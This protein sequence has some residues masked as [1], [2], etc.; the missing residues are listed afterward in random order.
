MSYL[1]DQNN[2]LSML[3]IIDW[4]IL[5]L[6]LMLTLV[7]P[8]FKLKQFN[9]RH[10][11]K[12][13]EDVLAGRQ[14]TMVPFVATLF[15]TWYGG[16]FG[17]SEIAY[18]YGIYNFL[19]QGVFF[20]FAYIIFAL[21]FV[22]KIRSSLAISLPDFIGSIYGARA[23]KISSILFFFKSIP[24]VYCISIG[25]FIN[26]LS[27]IPIT[28][29]VLIGTLFA[30]FY[31]FNGGL[32]AIVV[33]DLL[34]FFFMFIGIIAL[35]ISSYYN[36][37]GNAYLHTHL[38]PSY[39]SITSNHSFATT[40]TWFLIATFSIFLSPTFYQRCQAAQSNQTAKKG[41]FIALG[42]W[43]IFDICV[44]LCAMYAKAYLPNLAP[45]SSVLIYGISI[46]PQG[47]KGLILV[48]ICATILSSLDSYIFMLK[49]TLSYD[50]QI[51]PKCNYLQ[52]EII[53]FSIIIC[54]SLLVT[55]I[56]A[57]SIE[58]YWY[59][60]KSIFI[61]ILGIPMLAG[62]FWPKLAKTQNFSLNLAVSTILIIIGYWLNQKLKLHIELIYLAIL[63]SSISM[64]SCTLGLHYYANRAQ[65]SN[66]I[67]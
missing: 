22:S 66:N 45:P 65:T 31:S 51:L 52:R 55:H 25:L 21:A 67:S 9:Y 53:I 41:I 46:L 1:V 49:T 56:F 26:L 4:L 32:R 42:F 60:S 5:A 28:L 18:K 15:T 48:S 16:I 62:F 6:S 11:N 58:S 36:F 59:W 47:F 35:L 19:T 2:I 13:I 10:S 3:S 27:G 61:G 8:H 23:K 7:L 40:G 50:L 43:V 30:A 37:G 24:V 57:A 29:G 64:L 44:T 34:Q 39:F 12:I 20:Y 33:T 63:S 14:L 54:T 38:P 17:V